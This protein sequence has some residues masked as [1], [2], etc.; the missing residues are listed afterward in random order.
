MLQDPGGTQTCRFHHVGKG[1][2]QDGSWKVPRRDKIIYSS[3]YGTIQ[4]NKNPWRIVLKDKAGRILSQTAALSDADS[5]QVKYTPFC[6]VKRGKRQVR[7]INPVFT[8]TADEMIFGCGESAT[9]LNKAGQ[10]VNLFVTDPQGPETDQMYNRF[11][12]L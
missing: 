2:G 10:K 1:T 5:T 9:G 3:D 8:L 7:R 4:I 6:F 11:L 12:S